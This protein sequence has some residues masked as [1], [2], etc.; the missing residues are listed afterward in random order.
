MTSPKSPSPQGISTRYHY[1]ITITWPISNTGY[2]QRSEAGVTQV[3]AG[4]TRSTVFARLYEQIVKTAKDR[5]WDA[6]SANILF[7]SLEPED[8]IVSTGKATQ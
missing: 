7:F 6:D 5:G 8:L 2:G 4:E 1:V 3:H